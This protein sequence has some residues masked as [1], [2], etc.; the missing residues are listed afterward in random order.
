[1]NHLLRVLLLLCLFA[2]G[3]VAYRLATSLHAAPALAS[4]GMPASALAQPRTAQ[5]GAPVAG[6]AADTA[7]P[8][9]A[10]DAG[11]SPI[12]LLWRVS[13]GDNDVYLLGSFHA[14]KPSDYPLAPAVD[15][16]F[17]DAELVA[18]EIPPAEMSSPDLGMQM[19]AAASDSRRGLADTLDAATF[20]RLKAYCG[21]RSIPIEAF[22]SYEPWFVGL[23]ISLSEMQRDGF[24]PGQGLDQQLIAR[25]AQARKRTM[26]LETG[27]SQIA[28]L[29]GMSPEEQ[30]QSLS[31]ALDDAEDHK[32]MD[33][34][35]DKWRR[36][37]AA[38][39]ESMLTVDFRKQYASLYQRIN[40]DRNNAWIPKLRALLDDEHKDDAL[41]VVGTMHLLGPDGLVSQL[42]AKGYR[43]ERL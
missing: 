26:G 22:E 41:V 19:M 35:H 29:D 9:S 18:F 4:Q 15:A 23:M 25:A 27:A 17:D 21:A 14:L 10:R 32:A 42:R 16:A 24:D 31:E 30:K 33:D 20:A 7:S 2:G 43:V 3:Y 6:T 38:A 5:P 11:K 13:D 39:L 37:D 1:M 8:P 28:V 36:G 12:P 34:L 40:V